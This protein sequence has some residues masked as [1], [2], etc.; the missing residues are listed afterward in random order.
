[1]PS[2]ER[3]QRVLEALA[4]RAAPFRQALSAVRDEIEEYLAAHRPNAFTAPDSP[5]TLG[6]FAS[7]RIDARRFDAILSARRVLAAADVARLE[8]CLTVI[9]DTLARGDALSVCEVPRGGDTRRAIEEELDKAGRA[10]AAAR[11]F[12]AVKTGSYRAEQHGTLV[13]GLQFAEWTRT[14][15]ELVPPLV[16]EVEGADLRAETVVDLLDRAAR[17]VFVVNGQAS[18]APLVRLISPN[19]FVIQTTDVRALATIGEF[20]GP[21]VVAIIPKGCAEFVH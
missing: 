5:T 1:M 14:E 6:P 8:E 3:T 10:F 18:P 19:T 2:D 17:I 4:D 9:T 12:V 13:R 20:S 21:A 15:R 16:V 11:V 7:G